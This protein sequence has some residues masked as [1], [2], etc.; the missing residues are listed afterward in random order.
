[1]AECVKCGYCCCV[2]A[3][4]FGDYDPERKRCR[5]L[6]DDN[7][8]MIYDFIIEQPGAVICPAFGT[9]CSSSLFNERRE[10][11]LKEMKE[12]DDEA[13]GPKAGKAIQIR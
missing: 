12:R 7:T 6:D 10:Q 4:P 5:F 3:C 1:M 2:G 8:C 11:K 9:G 13:R